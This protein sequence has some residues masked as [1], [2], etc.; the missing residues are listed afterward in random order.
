[1]I[2]ILR[3]LQ[4]E[5]GLSAEILRA[6]VVRNTREMRGRVKVPRVLLGWASSLG[7]WEAE[8]Q[9]QRSRTGVSGATLDAVLVT[10]SLYV[11]VSS[12][13]YGGVASLSEHTSSDSCD[14]CDSCDVLRR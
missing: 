10:C 5:V 4:D 6:A 11:T 3:T 8:A 14:L 7:K 12:G 1:M 2:L 13:K 9:R